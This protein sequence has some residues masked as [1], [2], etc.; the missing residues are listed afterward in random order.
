M[1]SCLK[2]LGLQCLIYVY[3]SYNGY[4][5]TNSLFRVFIHLYI[6]SD[7]NTMYS[8]TSKPNPL[9]TRQNGLFRKGLG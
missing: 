8:E 4:V 9:R 6:G 1:I 5:D 2:Q 3:I 7:W